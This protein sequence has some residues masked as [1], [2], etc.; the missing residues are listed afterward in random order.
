ME[1]CIQQFPVEKGVNR[2]SFHDLFHAETPVTTASSTPT[3]EQ[4]TLWLEDLKNLINDELGRELFGVFLKSEYSEENLE[5]WLE[6]ENFKGL[7]DD[8]EERHG[9]ATHIFNTFVKPLSEKEV[10]ISGLT[11]RKIASDLEGEQLLS[12][13]FDDAQAQVYRLMQGQSYPRFKMSS[14]LK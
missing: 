4:I 12:N 7:D 3:E 5:F 8:S 10:N 2:L 1:C 11:R 13:M 9:K 14:L 6:V